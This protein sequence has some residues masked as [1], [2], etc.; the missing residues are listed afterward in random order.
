[1]ART[2]N[3]SD[4]IGQNLKRGYE[5]NPFVAIIKDELDK[6]FLEIGLTDDDF[7]EH[8]YVDERHNQTEATEA[9]LRYFP[10]GIKI[11]TG[12]REL[13]EK[14]RNYREPGLVFLL[15]GKKGIGKT[16]FLKNLSKKITTIKRNRD[17]KT[18][19]IYLDLRTRKTDEKFLSSLPDSLSEEIYDYIFKNIPQIYQYL[20]RPADIKKLDPAFEDFSDKRLI[21]KFYHERPWAIETLFKYLDYR[22]FNLIIIIDN[23]DDFGEKYVKKILHKCEGLSNNYNAKCILAVRDNWTP[24][25]LGIDD[26]QK[27]S[28]YEL[29]R[30]SI[31]KIIEKR[32]KHIK[33]DSTLDKILIT[34]DKKNFELGADDVI[35]LHNRIIQDLMENT[36]DIQ[37]MLYQLANY[38]VRDFLQYLYHYFHSPYLYSRPNFIKALVKDDNNFSVEKSRSTRFFDFIECLMTPNAICYN[39]SFS[40]I[41]NIFFHSWPYNEGPNFKNTL[42]FTRILQTAPEQNFPPIKKEH[43]VSQLDAIGY[44][45]EAIKNAISVLLKHSLLESPQGTSYDDTEEILLSEKGNIYL[46]KLI[47]EYSYILFISDAVPMAEKYKVDIN[48]KF[49]IEDIPLLRGDLLAKFDCVKKFVSFLKE[50]EEEE[51]KRCPKQSDLSLIKGENDLWKLIEKQINITISKMQLQKSPR[52]KITAI[53]KLS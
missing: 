7:L 20:H 24:A 48:D 41:F 43:I 14:V 30:P 35:N 2:C 6:V 50:E 53:K 3:I 49:G 33:V 16:V 12:S 26:S 28:F 17:S 10:M 32:L 13:L 27:I 23:I 25:R 19:L 36:K 45:N 15:I 44:N 5:K 8:Y 9:I 38:N 4:L 52:P 40:S 51:R 34:Y 29:S 11:L 21:E 1:M 46:H 47:L 42:I 18:L 22:R 31:E 39:A 37:N